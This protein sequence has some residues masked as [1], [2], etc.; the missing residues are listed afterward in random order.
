MKENPIRDAI[1]ELEKVLFAAAE[2]AGV[3]CEGVTAVITQTKDPAHG[4]FSTNLALQ[5]A[6]K[7]KS[8][9]REIAARIVEKIDSPFTDKVEIAGPGFINFYMKQEYYDGIVRSAVTCGEDYGKSDYFKGKKVMVEFVS[10][11]PTG[12]MHMGNARGGVVG[13]TLATLLQ[14]AGCDVTREFYVNDSGN[15][16]NILARSLYV[17]YVQH[18]KGEDSL[19]FPEDGYHGEDVKELACGFA[20]E[21]GDALLSE[22]EEAAGNLLVAYALK[23]NISKMKA[24]LENYKIH[25][26]V[27]F[28]ESQLH[29]S[30]YVEETIKMLTNR[31]HTYEKDGALWFSASRF[32]CE[33]DEV[34]RKSN[35]FY[36]YYAVDIAYHRNKFEKRGFDQVIDVLGADHHGH[37]LRFR[38]GLAAL[39]LLPEKLD[40]V[41]IQLVRLLRDGEVVRMSKRTGKTISLADLLQEIPVDAARFFFD[42]KMSDSSMD[43]DLN[44][45]VKQDSDNPVYYIQ[46][47]HAR[48]CSILKN[49]AAEGVHA[50]EIDHVNLSLLA[51]P[52]EKELIRLIAAL[53]EEILSCAQALEPTRITRYAVSV[54]AAFHKFYNACYVRTDNPALTQ[55]RLALCVAVRQVLKNTFDIINIDAPEQM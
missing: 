16:V 14:Y 52:E 18:F 49:L 7:T 39:G 5:L 31:G 6:S 12:P 54:S 22:N 34:L 2:R 55:A 28:F 32:G 42:Y 3:A 10:A 29:S 23:K 36:T 51:A 45:A 8:K 33:K 13:D 9:P 30:G 15:Q 44:L 35:G 47:A 46:Y 37:T 25:Y 26:D 11:N 4:E 17:R 19:P 24:D 48:I 20:E 21:A 43:F 40:F 41:L 50:A 27:W 38:A 53:P 1:Q